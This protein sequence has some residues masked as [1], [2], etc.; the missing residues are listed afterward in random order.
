M[1]AAAQGL[2]TRW[3]RGAGAALFTGAQSAYVSR[4]SMT[5][6][7]SKTDRS[8]RRGDRIKGGYL[9]QGIASDG[10]V[11]LQPQHGRRQFTDEQ[12]RAAVRAA[13]EALAEQA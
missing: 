10:T 11:I 1:P 13:K 4:M 8:V 9:V 2:L 3:R 5:K 12:L 6:R 7:P